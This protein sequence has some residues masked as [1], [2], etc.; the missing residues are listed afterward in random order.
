MK[1]IKIKS[2][3]TFRAGQI[4]FYTSDFSRYSL[5]ATFYSWLVTFYSLLVT[6]C[7]LLFTRLLFLFTR[8]LLLLSRYSLLFTR[9]SLLLI[10]YLL[11][12][13]RYSLLFIHHYLFVIEPFIHYFC[14]LISTI[15][16]LNF[17]NWVMLRTL[18]VYFY[19]FENLSLSSP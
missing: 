1:D 14:S 10:R 18:K 3:S 15:Y 6:F 2:I 9:C 7:S 8:Y 4:Y 12:L 16:L 19:R 17:G 5:L 11:P 13:T